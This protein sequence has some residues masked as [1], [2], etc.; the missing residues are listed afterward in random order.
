MNLIRLNF[1]QWNNIN[2][3][4]YQIEFHMF[5]KSI[6]V[7]LSSDCLFPFENKNNRVYYHVQSFEAIS[8]LMQLYKSF[9]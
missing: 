3:T 8:Y 5:M 4:F 2:S 9:N 6:N 7:I 1:I